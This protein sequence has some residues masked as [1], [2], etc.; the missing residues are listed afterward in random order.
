[1]RK[2]DDDGLSEKGRFVD[3]TPSEE[4]VMRMAFRLFPRA[5]GSASAVF[6]A[7]VNRAPMKASATATDHHAEA[8]HRMGVRGHLK[9]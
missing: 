3:A 2:F 6:D 9:S 7:L 1:M 5:P 8:E 4:A